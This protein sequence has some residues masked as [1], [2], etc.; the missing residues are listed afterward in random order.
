MNYSLITLQSRFRHVVLAD[1]DAPRNP[2]A[3]N[4]L[5]SAESLVCCDRAAATA[6]R[7]GLTPTAVVGDGDSIPENLREHYA[8]LWHHIAEQD[9]ND[10]TKA[11]RWTMSLPTFDKQTDNTVCYLGATGKREDHTISNI[12]LMAYYLD[13]YA[14]NPVMV[15]DYGWFVAIHGDATLEVLPRQ[16]VS[17]FNFSCK[18]LDATGLKWKPWAFERLWCGSLNE[19]LGTEVQ[20]HADGTYLIYRTFERKG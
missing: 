20:F 6:F 18:H 12:S 8:E 9:S 14:L 7:L 13:E 19:A 2:I 15:T 4:L 11:T 17:I 1:G 16:Q 3:C 5:K 10:L